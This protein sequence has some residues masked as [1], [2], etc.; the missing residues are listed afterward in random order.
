M[1]EYI[2]KMKLNENNKK[3]SKSRSNS[4]SRSRSRSKSKE[5]DDKN[6]NYNKCTLCKKSL[7]KDNIMDHMKNCDMCYQCK[8]CKMIVEI[9]NLTQHRLNEC[10]KKDKL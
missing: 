1:R 5:N 2:S 4:K 9:R 10:E 8:K 7:G 6:E 3:K